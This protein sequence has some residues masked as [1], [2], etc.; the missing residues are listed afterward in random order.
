MKILFFNDFKLGV[1]KGDAVVDVSKLVADIPHTGPHDLINGWIERFAKVKA[2][3]E[4]AAATGK[5]IPL[6][7]VR[8]RPPLPRP[9]RGGWLSTAGPRPASVMLRLY[10][11]AGARASPRLGPYKSSRAESSTSG[12]PPLSRWERAGGRASS[13]GGEDVQ[14]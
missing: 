12:R 7:R 8:I 13:F 3:L 4:K 5:G 6:A 10:R 2:K 9:A 14:S 1:L 11:V